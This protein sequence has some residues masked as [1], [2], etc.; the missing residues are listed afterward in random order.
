MEEKNSGGCHM[1]MW[2][3]EIATAIL[4]FGIAY[5]GA[6]FLIALV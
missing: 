4:L 3:E 5:L 1:K 2:I 6:L